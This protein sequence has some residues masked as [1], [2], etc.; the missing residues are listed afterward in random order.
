[1][2]NITR[3][4]LSHERG[5]FSAHLRAL[6]PEDR[7][8]RFGL[9]LPDGAIDDYATRIDFGRDAVFGVFDDQLHLAGAAHLARAPVHAELGVSVLP[10]C[11]GRGIGAALL[12]RAHLHARNWGIGALFMHCLT[13][14][15]A[16]M[17]LARTQGMRI[18]AERGEADAHLELPPANPASIAQALFDERVGL[19]DYALKAQFDSLRRLIVAG[20]LTVPPS[21][22]GV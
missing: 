21:G 15:G 9:A 8:L 19:F 14:N 6:E 20:A 12:A 5:K 2:P 18:V 11:R 10:S 13:E 1:M 3:E 22:R 17:H 4:L 16:M 7:R